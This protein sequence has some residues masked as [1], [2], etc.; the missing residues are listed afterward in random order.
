MGQTEISAEWKK[1]GRT[2]QGDRVAGAKNS[3]W[4]ITW[5]L[6]VVEASSSAWVS[7][8]WRL[9]SLGTVNAVLT[10]STAGSYPALPQLNGSSGGREGWLFS[11][12]HLNSLLLNA[13]P[14]D[15]HAAGTT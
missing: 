10:A 4:F 3:P 8:V 2:T 1:I 9:N 7:D 5:H 13:C 14:R 11:E 6:V 15:L 12:A